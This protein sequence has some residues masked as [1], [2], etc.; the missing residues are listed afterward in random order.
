MRHD[1]AEVVFA[2]HELNTGLDIIFVVDTQHQPRLVE[3]G[4]IV[5]RYFHLDLKLPAAQGVQKRGIVH[6]K[7]IMGYAPVIGSGSDTHRKRTLF[8]FPLFRLIEPLHFFQ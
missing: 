7:P 4:L 8:D 2:V 5:T 3:T 6:G 1:G